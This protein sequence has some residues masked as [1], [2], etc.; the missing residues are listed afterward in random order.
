MERDLRAKQAAL[1]KQKELDE[2]AASKHL[3]GRLL[4]FMIKASENETPLDY[5]CAGLI[6]GAAR[7]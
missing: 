2:A 1:N 5:S 4:S 6:L 3:G 7:T